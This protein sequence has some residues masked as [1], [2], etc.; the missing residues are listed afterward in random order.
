MEIGTNL[1]ISGQYFIAGLN[2]NSTKTSFISLEGLP[3]LCE[4]ASNRFL[5]IA[6]KTTE[7][8]VIQGLY[9]KTL[10]E[11]MNSNTQFD[12]VFFDGN[13]QYNATIEYFEKLKNNYSEDVILIFDDINWSEGMAK[14]WEYLK[15]Q[16][17]VY[18]IIDFF[19]TGIILYNPNK[20]VKPTNCKLFLTL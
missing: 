11:V 13:H 5:K 9:D 17:G 18:C 14:A 12:I 19:K 8:K 2:N 7:T 4:I 1:G 6:S 10:S 16:S 3:G 15:E 20:K